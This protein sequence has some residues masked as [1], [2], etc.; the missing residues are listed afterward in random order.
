MLEWIFIILLG[1]VILLFFHNQATFEFK[2]SQ[3]RWDQKDTHLPPLLAER[4]PLV[5]QGV[6]PVAFWTSQDIQRRALYQTVPVF[7]DQ[8][9]P[10]WLTTGPPSSAPC[11]WTRDHARL[12]GAV[13]GLA[14]WAERELHPAVHTNPLWSLWYRPEVSCWAGAKSLWKTSCRWTCIVPTE[15]SLLVSLLAGSAKTTQSLPPSLDGVFPNQLTVYDTPFVADLQYMDIVLRQGSCL[16]MP[17][18]WYM[19]WQPLEETG[20]VPLVCVVEYHTP[21]SLM[22]Q[23]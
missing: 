22:L 18:H 12:L 16:I 7:E 6:P 1:A 17:S 14:T 9:L 23:A 2:V 3:I 10:E 8:T 21:V 5:I 15:G 20:P 11:P 4:G 19:S 13:S